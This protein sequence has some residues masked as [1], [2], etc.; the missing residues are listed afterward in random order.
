MNAITIEDMMFHMKMN[1]GKAYEV[2]YESQAYAEIIVEL[3]HIRIGQGMS[4]RELAGRCGVKPRIIGRI[5]RG[6]YIPRLNLVIRIA[7]AL[8]QAV[9]ISPDWSRTNG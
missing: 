5:E 1:D 7:Y 6:R 9:S 2:L 8:G 4:Q 3:S